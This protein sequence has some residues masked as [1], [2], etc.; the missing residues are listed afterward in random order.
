MVKEISTPDVMWF[1]CATSRSAHPINSTHLSNLYLRARLSELISRAYLAELIDP[2][3][4]G[5][6]TRPTH[7][8]SSYST[9]IQHILIHL[10]NSSS[11]GVF[12]PSSTHL[13]KT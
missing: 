2:N 8:A 10:L 1:L 12:N 6:L 5:Q 11:E 3:S 7:T 4:Y 9:H 13:R